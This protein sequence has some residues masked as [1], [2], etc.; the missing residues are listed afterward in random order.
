MGITAAVV[1]TVATVASTVVQMQAAKK[2]QRLQEEANRQRKEASDIS[3]AQSENV[4]RA[5]RRQRIREERVRR[6]QIIQG[7]SNA[8]VGESSGQI[9]SISV[10]GTNTGTAIAQSFAGRRARSGIAAANQRAV[11][12]D[13]SAQ[14]AITRGALFASAIGAFSTAVGG[15]AKSGLFSSPSTPAVV[16]YNGRGDYPGTIPGTG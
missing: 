2:A 6:A 8:G 5:R 12:L 4:E 1:A 13:T 14:N 9:G 15:V 10:L 11:D 16:N 3:L 7:A